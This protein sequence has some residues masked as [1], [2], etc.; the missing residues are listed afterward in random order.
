MPIYM[1]RHDIPREISPAHVA[2]MHQE[3]L[4]V[5]HLFGCRG[6]TY[7]CD[8][9]RS[10]AFCLIEA[11]NPDAIHAMHKHAH[12]AVPH[13]IIEVDS[14]IV[15]SFLGRISDP[16]HA[17]DRELHVITDSAFRVVM[18]IEASNFL[19]RLGANQLNIF[20]QKFHHSVEKS[21]EEHEGRI[22]QQDNLSYLISFRAVTNAVLCALKIH[23]NAKYITPRFDP[24]LRQ[25]HIGIHAGAPVDERRSL[26]GEVIN[27]TR[28]MCEYMEAPMVISMEVKTL[29]EKENRNA[30]IDRNTFR[31]L[32]PRED[33]FLKR[34]VAFCEENYAD[35][36]LSV[37]NFS[38]ALGYSKSRLYR[39]LK[40]LTGKSPNRFLREYRLRKALEML[41]RK[42]NSISE[43]AYETGF[44]N[45]AYFSKCFS[46]T[47]GILP[48]KYLRRFL[49]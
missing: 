3:D 44:N 49:A 33:E 6:M 7:W 30:R 17:A 15:E 11:P 38:E 1:D 5:Q 27:T 47:F 34:L 23:S 26:F 29:Y 24:G 18:N 16:E 45:P 25:L 48:S 8:P 35:E 22:V 19:H 9:E 39:S 32:G 41:R 21:L 31:I 37:P 42:D 46:E 14:K 12:G 20:T 40:S 10:A 36:D 13:K 4:K 28:N 2:Q 43:V